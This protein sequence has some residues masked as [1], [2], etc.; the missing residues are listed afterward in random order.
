MAVGD[1]VAA[2]RKR[3]Q[4]TQEELAR[5]AGLGGNQLSRI[6][7]GINDPYFG[8][9]ERLAEALGTDVPGLYRAGRKGA[10]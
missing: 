3:A 8:T 5:K 7:R 10:R 2:A 4:M 6:E 1:L 9:V